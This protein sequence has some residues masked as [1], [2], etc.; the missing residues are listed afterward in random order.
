MVGEGLMKAKLHGNTDQ[1]HFAI[2]RALLTAGYS[3]MDLSGV[4]NGL[5]LLCSSG[6]FTCL[7]EVKTADGFIY[8]SQLLTIG[9]WRGSVAFV[10]SEAESL[11]IMRLR[12]ELTFI[13][14]KRFFL[15]IIANVW[16]F[17][18]KT[19][20]SALVILKRSW[21]FNFFQIKQGN[22]WE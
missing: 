5:D 16:F 8:L 15:F 6:D 1:N 11:E 9:S 3:V 12:K 18:G 7:L 13:Q 4:A 14:K 22:K 2:K 10:K 17:K 20:K 19:L 21:V